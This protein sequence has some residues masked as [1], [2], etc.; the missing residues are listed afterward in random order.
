MQVDM[1]AH[2]SDECCRSDGVLPQVERTKKVV[3][4]S[5]AEQFED[6]SKGLIPAVEL[7]LSWVSVPESTKPAPFTF[8]ISHI[9]GPWLP[10]QAAIFQFGGADHRGGAPDGLPVHFCFSSVMA[11]DHNH[12][13]SWAAFWL[14]PLQQ[15]YT[16][17]LVLHQCIFTM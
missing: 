8:A 5:M 7:R 10:F 4:S 15:S 2:S 17:R 14:H 13:R 6:L 16:D 1:F 11:V 9:L 12:I 3:F